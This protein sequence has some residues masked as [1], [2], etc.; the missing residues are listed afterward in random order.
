MFS[1]RLAKSVLILI[2]E[3]VVTTAA[4]RTAYAQNGFIE[5]V[6]VDSTA[7]AEVAQYAKKV[8]VVFVRFRND[9]LRLDG[10]TEAAQAWQEPDSLP[11]F[12]S[13]MFAADSIGPFDPRSLTDYFYKQSRGQLLLFGETYPDVFVT[14]SDHERYA[15]SSGEILLGTLAKEMLIHVDEDPRTDLSDFDVNDDGYL[16]YVIAVLRG[17]RGLRL[18][19]SGASGI[20]TLGYQSASPEFGS[21]PN[22]LKKARFFMGAWVLY[23]NAGNIFPALDL[24]RLI[25]HEMGHL[26]VSGVHLAPIAHPFG[27]PANDPSS[28]AYFLMSGRGDCAGSLTMSAVERDLR[29]LGWIACQALIGD[30]TVVVKDLY[31]ANSS[32]CFRIEVSG[33]GRGG[34]SLYL[35]NMQRVGDFDRLRTESCYGVRSDHGLMTTGLLATMVDRQYHVSVLA[36]DNS[37]DLGLLASGYDGDMFG[38]PNAS[39]LTP[40]TTPNVH[41]LSRYPPGYVLGPADFV[42][43]DSIRYATNEPRVMEFDYR[44]DFRQS[45]TIRSDSRIGVESE[46]VVLAGPVWVTDRSRLSFEGSASIRGVV[47]IE[48]GSVMRVARGT[49]VVTD[50]LYLRPGSALQIDG[51]LTVTTLLKNEGGTIDVGE[52]GQLTNLGIETV[53]HPAACNLEACDFTLEAFPNPFSGAV[54]LEVTILVT[55]QLDIE[56]FDAIGRSV[57]RPT[58]DRLFGSGRHL[59]TWRPDSEPSGVYFIRGR[60]E[61][62]IRTTSVVYVR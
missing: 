22:N 52:G 15:G 42:A 61:S 2:I 31:S 6:V 56:V 57:A 8:L 23:D 49:D 54:S 11:P 46:G 12:A 53:P 27:A 25:A 10:C 5:Q 38:P 36:A 35:S 62:V 45:P 4:L 29:H 13:V 30:T 55:S 40:W 33:P 9:S 21:D 43:V 26:F 47:T 44:A 18:A 1:P 39:Q 59:L 32:N 41:G 28:V 19:S 58:S 34:A 24:Y 50:T 16:D 48:S 51:G 14:A 37:I 3:A 7:T 60:S 20:A 17:R